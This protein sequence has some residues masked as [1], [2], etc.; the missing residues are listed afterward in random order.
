MES[1]W[2]DVRSRTEAKREYV[3]EKDWEMEEGLGPLRPS[4][5]PPR[6]VGM[7]TARAITRTITTR[8]GCR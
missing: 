2:D 7:P 6:D 8:N 5:P 3:L 1:W 4:A